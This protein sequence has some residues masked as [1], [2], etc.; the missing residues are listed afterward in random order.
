MLR[1]RLRFP[2][3]LLIV[4]LAALAG[5]APAAAKEAA[6][7]PSVHPCHERPAPGCARQHIPIGVKARLVERRGRDLR[8]TTA[9]LRGA[10][11]RYV[12]EGITWAHVE[13][14][15]GR[16][17]WTSTDRWM[18]AAARRRLRVIA[19][20]NGPPPWVVR[21]P[22]TPASLSA[23]V[24]FAKAVARR[25]GSRGRFWKRRP[26][27]PK[28]PIAFYDVWNEPYVPRFWGTAPDP[29]PYAAMFKR[30]AIGLKRTDPR[31]RVMLEADTRVL[32]G[33]VRPFLTAM[34]DAAPDLAGYVDAVS[35]HPYQEGGGD[36]RVCTPFATSRGIDYDWKATAR[37]FCRIR[38]IR[39]ILDAHGADK[40]K[41]WITEVG[42]STAPLAEAAV[43]EE[44]QA[45]R[46][47]QTFRMLRGRLRGLVDG[48][49]WYEYEG[50]GGNAADREDHFGL[51]RSGGA[52]K[53]A[54]HAF[55]EEARRGV[56]GRRR[57]SRSR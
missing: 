48:L 42:W 30:T 41:L 20:L 31:A 2:G 1:N 54:W 15:R 44:V 37:Q 10:R 46:V 13:R 45:L 9:R 24:R 11:V 43:S 7:G 19:I 28:N 21:P 52:A 56:P 6:A 17:N 22:V 57:R 4:G 27:L 12:R 3:S 40:A 47:R 50:P 51:V 14:P 5:S 25:Y 26:S 36:P 23:Y 8:A 49:V 32:A 53:P 55:V 29:A 33:G 35:A 18:A 16:F 34:F 39:R 38:D